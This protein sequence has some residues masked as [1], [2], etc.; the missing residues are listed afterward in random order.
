MLP[1]L[2]SV[3]H[4]IY[5]E[6][7]LLHTVP[8][9][10]THSHPLYQQCEVLGSN[11]IRDYTGEHLPES[12]FFFKLCVNNFYLTVTVNKVLVRRPINQVNVTKC[13]IIEMC[14]SDSSN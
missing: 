8:H 11:W 14:V 4:K 1:V 2:Y 5:R 13:A 10:N 7:F 12:N 6:T 9:C 3:L